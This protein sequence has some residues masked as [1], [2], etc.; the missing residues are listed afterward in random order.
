MSSEVDLPPEAIARYIE[1]RIQDARDCREALNKGD[2]AVLLKVGHQVK[3]NA[4]S[5][6]F[7][8][9][10]EIAVQLEEFALKKDISSLKPILE[11]FESYIAKISAP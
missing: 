5:F 1:R 3:G 10:G 6:G 11:K 2:F 7:A 4:I 8:E 9:L